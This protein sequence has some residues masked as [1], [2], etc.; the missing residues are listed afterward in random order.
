MF[1]QQELK[2]LYSLVYQEMDGYPLHRKP[3]T[4][5]LRHL[6]LKLRDAEN[7]IFRNQK[8]FQRLGIPAES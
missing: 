2:I 5:E 3:S 1:T 8:L 4:S 6:W 7:K